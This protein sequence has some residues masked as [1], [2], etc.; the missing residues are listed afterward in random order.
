MNRSIACS[1]EMITWEFVGTSQSIYMINPNRL[2]ISSIRGTIMA[3]KRLVFTRNI[4]IACLIA[5][6]IYIYIYIEKTISNYQS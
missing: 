1:S 2:T 6:Y 5:E 3:I 4:Y